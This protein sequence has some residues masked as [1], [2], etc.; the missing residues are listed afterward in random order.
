MTLFG[1]SA[2]SAAIDHYGYSY[3]FDPIVSG[4]IMESGAAGFGDPLPADHFEGWNNVSATL[5]CGTTETNSSSEMLSCLQN[6]DIKSILAAIGSNYFDPTVDGITGFPDYAALSRE[7]KFAQIPILIGNNDFEA[8]TYIP[9]YALMNISES[10]TYWENHDNLTFACPAGARANISVSHALPTWRYRWFGDF[11]NA[12]IITDPDHDAYAYHCGEIPFIWDTLPTGP[13]IGPDTGEEVAIRAY[14]QGAWA[15][16]AKNPRSGLSTYEGGWP[17]YS[18]HEPTLIRLAY[19]NKTGTNLARP[20]TYD[21]TCHTTY[22][23]DL[24]YTEPGGNVE[25]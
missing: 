9:E 13:G 16:F 11:P 23:I 5:N 14:V 19:D 21:S 8:G 4:F 1:Q 12:R 17:Q 15:A 25:L 18:P 22:P 2:G 24:E 7:G 3:A 20:E 6:K 10:R